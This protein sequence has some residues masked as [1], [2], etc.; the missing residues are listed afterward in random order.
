MT[1]YI[2]DPETGSMRPRT[3]DA[4]MEGEVLYVPATAAPKADTVAAKVL[5]GL[6]IIDGR[7]RHWRDCA[8]VSDTV[9]DLS[10]GERTVFDEWWDNFDRSLDMIAAE[11]MIKDLQGKLAA[12]ESD[13]KALQDAGANQ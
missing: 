5:G 8:W 3:G 12:A 2:H 6:I 9:D 11:L 13:L 1:D 4:L 7:R 10:V